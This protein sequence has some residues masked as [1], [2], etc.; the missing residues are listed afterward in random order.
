MT[1]S[2]FKVGFI[3]ILVVGFA[4]YGLYKSKDFL[5]G[6]KIIIESPVNGQTVSNSY[7]EIKGAAKNVSLLY[8]NGRQIFTDRNG[9][10][11]ENLLLARGYNIIEVSAKDKFNRE[12]RLKR[13]VV[14]K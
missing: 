7:L 14:L 1:R 10:F 11:K 9:V 6:P 4:A 3:I 2:V 13:E 5:G 8:L 12:I